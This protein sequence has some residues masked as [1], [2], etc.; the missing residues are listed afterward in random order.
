MRTFA[1]ITG[2][3]LAATPSFADT[4]HTSDGKSISEVTIVS[5]GLDKVIYKDGRSDQ[6]IDTQ[7]VIS[8][9]FTEKPRAMMQADGFL[10][11]NDLDSAAIILNDYVDAVI[12]GAERE[13]RKWAPANAAW[14]VVELRQALGDLPGVVAASTRL[15]ENYG[16]TRYLPGAY[17]AKADAYYW[18]SDGKKAQATLKDFEAA[19]TSRMMAERWR[20]ECDLA[21]ILTNDELSAT[22]RRKSLDEVGDRAGARFAT[23]KNRSLVAQGESFLQEVVVTPAKAAKNVPAALAVF[24]EVLKD[25]K[26]D[27]ATL[28]GAYVGMGDCLFQSAAKSLDKD[29]LKKSALAYLRVAAV[30]PE[31]SRYVAKALFYGGRSLDLMGDDENKERAQVLYAEVYFSFPGSNWA[32]EAKNFSKR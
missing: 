2:L 29:E 17:L 22:A 19:I 8:I 21:L 28:A 1:L 26:A 11:D 18:N 20:M 32:N 4:I 15:I 12:S 13:R 10:L 5:E 25:P 24:Q 16:D 6:S 30:Y 23:V 7:S 14:R 27:D 9:V 31:Q 3:V